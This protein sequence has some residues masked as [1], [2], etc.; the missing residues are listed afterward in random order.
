MKRTIFALAAISLIA[1]PAIA[2]AQYYDFEQDTRNPYE[3][4]DVDDGQALRL[5]AYVLTPIG[6]GLE[7]GLMRPL[8]YAATE[9]A[10]APAL[11]G[12]KDEYQ[13]GQNNNADLVPPGTFNPEPMNLS[14]DFVHSP[15]RPAG[16]S[17][18]LRETIV[19]PSRASQPQ[20]H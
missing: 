13:F 10:L 14:N 3:Y 19:P 5:L 7:W 6:M 12:D 8:H 9:T 18:R 11:S 15:E 1:L 16:K 20:I 4:R 2:R 17:G